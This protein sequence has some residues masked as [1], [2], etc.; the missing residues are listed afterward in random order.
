ME[1]RTAKN[2]LFVG[3][4]VFGV[5]VGYL[6]TQVDRNFLIM[7]TILCAIIF[8]RVYMAWLK[9]ASDKAKK[10]AEKERKDELADLRQELDDLKT[11][12]AI[13]ASS[14]HFNDYVI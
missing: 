4:L 13:P 8:G 9:R 11:A 2:L 1:K 3:I 10:K 12:S 7:I 14:S 6:V 5:F